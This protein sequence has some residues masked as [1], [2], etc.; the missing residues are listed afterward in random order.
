MGTIKFFM[1]VQK[2]SR[3]HFSTSK[4]DFNAGLDSAGLDS[5]ELDDLAVLNSNRTSVA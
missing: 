5:T 4:I 3:F 1:G 2:T